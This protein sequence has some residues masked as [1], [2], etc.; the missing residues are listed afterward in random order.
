MEIKVL[1]LSFSQSQKSVSKD[2]VTTD[3]LIV[4][5]KSDYSHRPV[6]PQLY[7][8]LVSFFFVFFKSFFFITLQWALFIHFIPFCFP[9]VNSPPVIS[10]P[11][12]SALIFY[13]LFLQLPLLS[14][15]LH[16]SSPSFSPSSSHAF[17][18]FIL[19]PTPSL[20]F[21]VFSS[22][23]LFS[24]S[25]EPLWLHRYTDCWLCRGGGMLFRHSTRRYCTSALCLLQPKLLH[26]TSPSAGSILYSG[27][28][29]NFPCRTTH[30]AS[31]LCE[32]LKCVPCISFHKLSSASCWQAS[33]LIKPH[34]HSPHQVN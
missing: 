29:Y 21:P 12:L 15:C 19:S 24:V 14:F 27:C 5:S 9:S 25:V 3:C 26:Q 1:P 4:S 8:L 31:I 30:W 22:P 2:N 32:S 20:H 16:S 13:S 28:T 17:H 23:S 6:H 11:A 7:I 18:P 34:T 10:H 33:N